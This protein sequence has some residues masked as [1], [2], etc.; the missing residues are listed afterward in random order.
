MAWSSLMWHPPQLKVLW[1]RCPISPDSS[2][3]GPTTCGRVAGRSCSSPLQHK[4]KRVCKETSSMCC[5]QWPVTSHPPLQLG[6]IP[7][8]CNLM[9]LDGGW[10]C[11][12]V[13]F[14]LF[15][16]Q[17][18]NLELSLLPLLKCKVG[19]WRWIEET[20]AEIHKTF[21]SA[22]ALQQE[23]AM[24]MQWNAIYQ[25]A[26]CTP[27]VDS[28]LIFYWLHRRSPAQFGAGSFRVA[29]SLHM[30]GATALVTQS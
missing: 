28:L 21:L 13:P 1:W 4:S 25:N 3:I 7:C 29:S 9:L 8:R 18:R 20:T 10:W 15:Q 14:D 22:R 11:S 24:V 17:C 27:C 5:Y 6:P 2:V 19:W 26:V 30:S 23:Q 16:R 12:H